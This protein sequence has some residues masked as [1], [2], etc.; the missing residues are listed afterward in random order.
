MQRPGLQ[1][2]G[3]SSTPAAAPA[4]HPV[5]VWINSPSKT[6]DSISRG[7]VLFTVPGQNAP[8]AAPGQMKPTMQISTTYVTNADAVVVAEAVN[9]VKIRHTA[10]YMAS[11]AIVL[12]GTDIVKL[13][14]DNKAIVVQD[15]QQPP[16]A[17]VW[18][19]EVFSGTY[20][21]HNH[22]A[23]LWIGDDTLTDID[24]VRT[25]VRL[26]GYTSTAVTRDDPFAM[27][28]FVPGR[29]KPYTELRISKVAEYAEMIGKGIGT[30]DWNGNGAGLTI[31]QA[32]GIIGKMV[33][34]A[35]Y[36]RQPVVKETFISFVRIR[37][38]LDEIAASSGFSGS[39]TL[40][41]YSG[42]VDTAVEAFENYPNAAA[43]T[44]KM[45]ALVNNALT[46]AAYVYSL[47]F[48]KAADPVVYAADITNLHNKCITLA[49]AVKSQLG[50][51][52]RGILSAANA[53]I[54]YLTLHDD[55]KSRSETCEALNIAPASNNS[56]IATQAQSLP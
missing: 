53:L 5:V 41:K 2:S 33:T 9:W 37:V 43:V 6:P 39:D 38:S 36:S 13:P 28:H 1:Y 15:E 12:G 3:L 20:S 46:A 47:S 22:R 54:Q 23:Q 42:N 21:A 26:L 56:A 44:Y 45:K 34:G 7:T 49:A 55:L 40:T 11:V 27:T 31:N 35:L 19:F 8:P 29:V 52:A 30:P 17:P 24:G 18:L 32:F 4:T 48:L 10:N 25:G 16:G 14:E 51:C 50:A